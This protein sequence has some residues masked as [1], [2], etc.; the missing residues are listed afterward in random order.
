M[1]KSLKLAD[2]EKVTGNL[3]PNEVGVFEAHFDQDRY[4][5]RVDRNIGWLLEMVQEILRDSSVCIA[6]AGGMGSSVAEILVRKGVGKVAVADPEVYDYSN[7][8]RQ[9]AATRETIGEQKSL[10]T[11]KMCRGVADDTRILAYH[12]GIT[13]GTVSH[14][15]KQGD[16]ICDLIEFF[17]VAGRKL[18]QDS[19]AEL[20]KEV[21]NC[22]AVGFR[23]FFFFMNSTTMPL[24]HKL[25]MDMDYE[26]AKECQ[27]HCYRFKAA[28][29]RRK[30]VEEGPA[31]KAVA[32]KRAT[33]QQM[34][35]LG[36]AIE[37]CEQERSA[38]RQSGHLDRVIKAIIRTFVPEKV[39]YGGGEWDR[40]IKR[41]YEEMVVSIVASN[42]AMAA[43][44]MANRIIDTLVA[45]KTGKYSPLG[46]PNQ[47]FPGY[48]SFDSRTME[49][50]VVAPH[51]RKW[52]HL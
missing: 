7:L 33:P 47:L 50:R 18:L 3:G 36:E 4:R 29:D 40:F 16:L 34:L 26:T 52:V 30:G 21:V 24:G 45:Q 43:G 38:I 9:R 25:A 31:G 10:A 37:L 6:G 39:D 49:S 23:T 8:N 22:N 12:Q 20:G 5:K 17:C 11:A 44:F 13:E 46:I 28:L 19:A 41:L 2:L 15:L 32:Q 1:E 27:E 51:D 14:F 35:E 42:P 48:L